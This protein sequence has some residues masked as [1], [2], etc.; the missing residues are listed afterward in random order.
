MKLG[1][2]LAVVSVW[3]IGCSKEAPAGSNRPALGK[4]RGDCKA[5][6]V[7]DPGLMCLSNLCVRPPPADC[8]AVGEGLASYDLGNY[9]EPEERAPVIARYKAACEKAHVTKEQGECFEKA[10]DKTSAMMCAPFMFAT[11]KPAVGP[12]S[13]GGGDCAKVIARV[14]QTMQN[15]LS[16]ITDPQTLQMMNKAMTVMQE[17]CEQD[18]WP[19]SFKTCI[20]QAGDGTD[21]MSQCNQQ[22]PP[23]VQQK[24]ADRMMQM[25]QQTTP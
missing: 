5:D 3:A 23:D 21:A 14:R 8:N 11:T 18:S 24:M 2:A 13:G 6:K 16:Q 15:Q 12:G 17:S 19:D 10:T 20:L 25:M 4:E 9:A 1:M 7:C 22:M